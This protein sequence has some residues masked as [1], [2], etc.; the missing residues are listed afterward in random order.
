MQGKYKVFPLLMFYIFAVLCLAFRVLGNVF[1]TTIA[2]EINLYGLLMPAIFK[3]CIGL[4][5]V[6]VM[7]ELIIRVNQGMAM[8][9]SA[10]EGS[11]LE[12]NENMMADLMSTK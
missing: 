2:L 12:N 8:L 3:I 5:Q 1:A 9:H 10:N 6:M 11:F 4:V 7:I